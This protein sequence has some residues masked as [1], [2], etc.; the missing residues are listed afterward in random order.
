MRR[1]STVSNLWDWKVEA[2]L[3]STVPAI[4]HVS[5]E[6]EFKSCTD[7][8]LTIQTFALLNYN[9]KQST[10]E[11]NWKSNKS[12]LLGDVR[13]NTPIQYL[14]SVNCTLTFTDSSTETAGSLE[15]EWSL[16]NEIVAEFVIKKVDRAAG[17]FRIA[18][19]FSGYEITSAEYNFTDFQD[20]NGT[21]YVRMEANA[22]FREYVAMFDISG[23]KS[24]SSL[25]GILQLKTPFTDEFKIAVF[26][27]LESEKLNETFLV[28]LAEEKLLFVYLVGEVHS[29]S[30]MQLSAGVQMKN[31]NMNVTVRNYLLPGSLHFNCGGK[32]NNNNINIIAAGSYENAENILS[33]HFDMTTNSSL[34]PKNVKLAFDHTSYSRTIKTSLHLPGDIR[35]TNTLIISDSL[36]WKNKL[37]FTTP[38]N[39]GSVENKQTFVDGVRLEHEIVANLCGQQASALFTLVRDPRSFVIREARAFVIVPWT[40]PITVLYKLP[41]NNSIIRPSLV[42]RFKHSQEIRFETDLQY[43]FGESRLNME[44]TSPFCE[45]VVLNASYNFEEGNW[46]G[47]IL[48]KW[49][50]KKASIECNLKFYSDLVKVSGGFFVRHSDLGGDIAGGSFG[51]NLIDPEIT[52][53]ALGTYKDKKMGFGLSLMLVKN[54]YK[55]SLIVQTPFQNWENLSLSGEVNM[56]KPTKLAVMTLSKNLEDI[57]VSGLLSADIH[58]SN[59][60]V[61]L[62]SHIYGFQ[63]ISVYGSYD[64]SNSNDHAIE[65][66]CD[67]NGKKVEILGKLRFD[68]DSFLNPVMAEINLKTPFKGYE[69]LRAH[70]SCSIRGREMNIDLQLIKGSWKFIIQSECSFNSEEGNGKVRME[71]PFDNLK[72][73]SL[74]L[75]YG[76]RPNTLERTISIAISRNQLAVEMAGT[77]HITEDGSLRAGVI[78]KTP[79]NGYKQLKCNVVSSANNEQQKSITLTFSKDNEDYMLT[80]TFTLDTEARLVIVTPLKGYENIESRIGYIRIADEGANSNITIKVYGYLAVPTGKSKLNINLNLQEMNSFISAKIVS[81]FL[82]TPHIEIKG[83]YDLRMFPASLHFQ[84]NIN[85]D[86]FMSMQITLERSSLFGEIITPINGFTDVSLFGSFR[87]E[88]EKKQTNLKV[89]VGKHSFKLLSTIV[90]GVL[91]SEIQAELL[92]TLPGIERL[93]LHG[94]YNFLHNEKTAELIFTVDPSNIYELFMSGKADSMTGHTEFRMST[95][96]PEFKSLLFVAKYDLLHDY[97]VDLLVERN[98][99]QNNFGGH[100]TFTDDG[101]QIRFETPFKHAEDILL[102]ITY[103][104]GNNGRSANLTVV[105]NGHWTILDSSF[106]F[107]NSIAFINISTPYESVRELI[108]TLDLSGLS[109]DDKESSLS[110]SV[111][112]NSQHLLKASSHIF[113]GWNKEINAQFELSSPLLPNNSNNLSCKLYFISIFPPPKIQ[114]IVMKNALTAVDFR[115]DFNA[116]F[117]GFTYDLMLTTEHGKQFS[118]IYFSPEEKFVKFNIDLK[119]ADNLDQYIGDLRINKANGTLSAIFTSPI[120]G[121]EKFSFQWKQG[122]DFVD[123]KL[124]T[125]FKGYENHTVTANFDFRHINKSANL[126]FGRNNDVIDFRT[127]VEHGDSTD[128][129]NLHIV[130][131]FIMFKKFDFHTQYMKTG[132]K[133]RV[134][135]NVTANNH[136]FEICGELFSE[137]NTFEAKSDISSSLQALEKINANFFFNTTESVALGGK[138]NIGNMS[139][140]ISGTIDF[141]FLWGEL[142]GTMKKSD[143]ITDHRIMWRLE[144]AL[145]TAK[146]IVSHGYELNF[147]IDAVLNISSLK[148]V[149]A[150]LSYIK[151]M[152]VNQLYPYTSTYK[153][154]WNVRNIMNLNGGLFLML[155][156]VP[157]C[158]LNFNVDFDN[159]T[160]INILSADYFGFF[161]NYRIHLTYQV[162]N[163]SGIELTSEI[164]LAGTEILTSLN[165]RPYKSKFTVKYGKV[166]FVLSYDAATEYKALDFEYQV[167]H[168]LYSL[169]SNLMLH[170]SYLPLMSFTLKTPIRHY[171]FLHASNQYNMN[172]THK[173]FKILL[174][175]ED[176]NGEISFSVWKIRNN[177]GLEGNMSL[178]V[179]HLT[180]W[181]GIANL[182]MTSEFAGNVYCSRNSTEHLTV[183]FKYA[184]DA[185]KANI[186]A[187][188]TGLQRVKFEFLLLREYI[189]AVL[190]SVDWGE[191]RFLL[192]GTA[193]FSNGSKPEF[194]IFCHSPWTDPFTLL[195]KYINEETSAVSVILQMGTKVTK[196]EGQI[197]YFVRDLKFDMDFLSD[198]NGNQ[199][200]AKAGY[201]FEYPTKWTYL[202]ARFLS[203]NLLI[204]S[205]LSSGG[206]EGRLLIKTPFHSFQEIA[207]DGI[208]KFGQAATLNLIWNDEIYTLHGEYERK[209]GQVN[210]QF[211]VLTPYIEFED[212]RFD[213]RYDNKSAYAKLESPSEVLYLDCSYHFQTY[214]YSIGATLKMPSVTLLKHLSFTVSVDAANLTTSATGQW[215]AS[216]AVNISASLLPSNRFIKVETP[217]EGFEKIVASCS[218]KSEDTHLAVVGMLELGSDNVVYVH[219][220]TGEGFMQH[221]LIISVPTY[222]KMNFN[223]TVQ[224][225]D[226][227]NMYTK[228]TYVGKSTEKAFSAEGMLNL[229]DMFLKLSVHHPLLEGGL[230]CK[231]L[232]KVNA[233]LQIRTTSS[234]Y[235][236]EGSY[237]LSSNDIAIK[238]STQTPGL[239]SSTLL[240]GSYQ[241]DRAELKTKLYFN[242]DILT[243][244]YKINKTSLAANFK[245]NSPALL[246]IKDFTLDIEASHSPK[247]YGLVSIK[248][249]TTSAGVAILLSNT[250]ETA[251]AQVTVHVQPLLGHL[252]HTVQITYNVNDPQNFFICEYEGET[253]HKVWMSYENNGSIFKVT[254]DTSSSILGTRRALMFM[255]RKWE[256]AHLD[257]MNVFIVTLKAKGNEG[258]LVVSACG[259]EH[260]ALYHFTFENGFLGTLAFESPLISIGKVNVTAAVRSEVKNMSV[261]LK[262]IMGVDNY[263]ATFQ[264]DSTEERTAIKAEIITLL[265]TILS[266]NAYIVMNRHTIQAETSLNFLETV[267]SIK[268]RHKRELPLDTEFN[269]MTPF[270]PKEI[271]RVILNTDNNSLILY[272]SHGDESYGEYIV[273]EGTINHNESLAF[274]NFKA[275]KLPLVQ[276]IGIHGIIILGD[277][278]RYDLGLSTQFS[279]ENFQSEFSAKFCYSSTGIDTYIEFLPP[280][281]DGERYGATIVIPFMLSNSMRPQISVNFGYNNTYSLHGTFINL[282]DV[283]QFG[284]GGQYKLRKLGGELKIENAPIP[285][286]QVEVDIPIGNS[287]GHYVVDIKG[288]KGK[289]LLGIENMLNY[290]HIGI[291]WNGKQVEVRYSLSYTGADRNNLLDFDKNLQ[292]TLVL[293]LT[294]PFYS[295]EKSGLK[296][297]VSLSSSQKLIVTTINYPGNSKPFGFEFN[298]Q[299]KSYKDITLVTQ[300]HIPFI[301]ALEDVALVLSNKFEE[302]HGTFKSAVGGHWN[303]EELAITLDGSSKEETV[304]KGTVTLKL[305]GQTYALEAN[306]GSP[307]RDLLGPYVLGARLTSPFE[308]VNNAEVHME[309]NLMKSVL[310]S[311]TQNSKE[312]LCFHIYSDE[313]TLL[314]FQMRSPGRS[315]YFVGS[316]DIEK[317]IMIHTELSW[318]SNPL[319]RLQFGIIFALS[320]GPGDRREMSASLKLPSRVLMFN[321]TNHVSPVHIEHACSFSWKK[322]QIIG[323]KT[324]FNITNSS[325]NPALAVVGHI[326]LPHRSFELGGYASARCMDDNM[327]YIDIGTEFLWDAVEDRNKKIGIAFRHYSTGLEIILQHVLMRND[328]VIRIIKH[329]R[330]LYDHLPF[331][332]RIEVEYSA[333][334]EE[335][336]TMEAH[337]HYPTNTALGINVG[338]SLC[339]KPTSTDFKIAVEVAQTTK[340]ST[341]R[342]SAEHLNSYTG[343]KHRIEIIGKINILQPEMKLAMRTAENQLE[344]HGLLKT[345]NNGHYGALVELLVNQK[346]PLSVEASV[347]L[348]EARVELEARNGNSQS[349][350]MYAVVPHCREI[351]MGLKHVF[352]E[353]E[354][355][356][357]GIMLRLNTS[358]Q[359]WSRIKWQ[360]QAL[361]EL[362]TGFLQEYSDITHVVQSISIGYSE[363]LLKD[364][365]YKYNTVYPVLVDMV[366]HTVSA[367]VTEVGEIYEDFLDMVEEMR[368]MYRR[369]DFYLQ[370]ILPHVSKFV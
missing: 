200:T 141:D 370:D 19:P 330:L 333:L 37:N 232:L 267:N 329:G 353:T 63:S 201:D 359:L 84:V 352:N 298:Y 266:L 47:K 170:K 78:V 104:T 138:L 349:Y 305:I 34:L 222:Y 332:V 83:E 177:V 94:Q 258:Y 132:T 168:Y 336:I 368:N 350:K 137:G 225:D 248:C 3:E 344:V 211:T 25:G 125:P 116:K 28:S 117:W 69:T 2:H 119:R 308:V 22:V 262:W 314:G 364:F 13:F 188:F 328:L 320:Y 182:D 85:G 186:N 338:F 127:S 255:K 70:Y 124:I 271:I 98:G 58:F 311:I 334:P 254:A 50:S 80:G 257:I 303:K 155:H 280:W 180:S 176:R 302:K 227:R 365:T 230:T 261:D 165:F 129:L 140:N 172:T 316:Y 72:E 306:Y 198:F 99:M 240:G 253:I 109:V 126:C 5:F 75:R 214:A 277:E 269:I 235:K 158:N 79:E 194:V 41:I 97:N 17:G 246:K 160:E 153:L 167:N 315:A 59:F 151:P 270:L 26:H 52:A 53:H 207:A 229:K 327:K 88:E 361:T 103:Q 343:H 264:L 236:M 93:T 113:I 237:V 367:S 347:H 224:F 10:V 281:K 263:H 309:I 251:I 244:C 60:S 6:H 318:E 156:N 184:P 38:R 307:K 30:N 284:F 288:H 166:H 241:Y 45:P 289:N 136:Q 212:I 48:T 285:G 223:V 100:V 205:S 73:L 369:N 31:Q 290:T 171:S 11:A 105:R 297:Y 27:Q 250:E 296:M 233:S 56:A 146:I 161:N 282:K 35:L 283:K 363:A 209:P 210:C 54:V 219:H 191:K 304:F 325:D 245:L 196:L 362:K 218:L 238:L 12:S 23:L 163:N 278:G 326:D 145:K 357:I 14:E 164:N 110:V 202:E 356:D 81:P 252:N 118:S 295:Y 131:P 157:V 317:D 139:A 213:I 279:S 274:F 24:N 272:G 366:H 7:N 174:Q 340:E 61:T 226:P 159:A 215:T 20:G 256:M 313:V 189:M 265:E 337:V 154:Q 175:K 4:A 173:G 323:F 183:N 249:N 65:L 143:Q 190:F 324:I 149:Q 120:V 32:W 276:Y 187:P 76:Y 360:P 133:Q 260:E 134:D 114:V 203:L 179:E 268:L 1:L 312:L 15:M 228:L 46:L 122:Y 77:L 49:G 199:V 71:L 148:N 115:S 36:N 220:I 142:S 101:T 144:D 55:G 192:N 90:F 208:L 273:L 294:T 195:S 82:M 292:C 299:L 331:T 348:A 39:T 243:S 40:D 293:E 286:M 321:L 147:V 216:Q 29:F 57:T 86:K 346:E 51:Y 242:E 204:N 322:D 92:T 217:F 291:E 87:I 259:M 106:K 247:L 162:M 150:Q 345:G 231:A 16:E 64:V 342:L 358:Q 68:N 355:E 8:Q 128:I 102:Y 185:L 43:Q 66:A 310:A 193:D 96:V 130:T 178:P 351:A 339:H 221:S 67:S 33:L 91:A 42:I 107:K 354:Y 197:K 123:T 21:T 18:T 341:G 239:D 335:L 95:P 181:Y 135:L 62:T 44:I 275:P 169:S 89:R 319:S 9:T 108:I 111:F 152:H 112:R 301:S 300:L 206:M 287:A 234:M 74:S 121:Y